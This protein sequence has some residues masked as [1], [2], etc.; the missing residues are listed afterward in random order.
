MFLISVCFRAA[1]SRGNRDKPGVVFYRITSYG[2]DEPRVERSVNSDIHGRDGGVIQ[3]ERERV[4]AHIRLLYCIIE[5]RILEGEPCSLDDIVA[6]FKSVIGGNGLEKGL[7]D[8]VER[9]KTDFSIRKDLVSIGREFK[10]EF[11]YICSAS[12]T[13][14][15]DRLSRF[16]FQLT[17]SLTKEQRV[18]QTRNINS[19]QSSL[20]DFTQTADIF[21]SQIDIGFIHDYADWLRHKGVIESTQSFYL[22]TLRSVLNKA[23]KEGLINM[24]G[25]WFKGVD[26]KIYGSSSEAH[27]IVSSEVL[28]RIANL[29][30]ADNSPLAL[31]RDMF[32]FGFYCEGM[33]LIDIA[34]LKKENIKGNILEYHRRLKGLKRSVVLG[35]QA[36]KILERYKNMGGQKYLFPLLENAGAVTFGTVGNYVRMCLLTI[37]Q[38]VGFPRLTFS[39]NISTYRAFVSRVSISDILFQHGTIA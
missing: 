13:D 17:Q 32:M 9:S 23:Y 34:N 35:E 24:S 22:R 14:D 8:I 7:Q 10:D 21:F 27:R 15:R 29:N 39:M 38:S 5:Q 18:S 20:L 2:S 28:H 30:L 25:D 4:I 1:R 11:S 37:G 26:T 31:V 6:D 3:I 36:K 16:V 12:M 33:E 19:L